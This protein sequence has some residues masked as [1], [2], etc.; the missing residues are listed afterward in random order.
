[1]IA[2]YG[3]NSSEK[4]MFLFILLPVYVVFSAASSHHLKAFDYLVDP[5]TFPAACVVVDDQGIS[6]YNYIFA[7]E[8]AGS[9]VRSLAL[10]RT[11]G[12]LLHRGK[13]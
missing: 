2:R 11:S 3:S 6:P 5:E 7:A 1:M 8:M 4:D 9:C 12:C 10:S 13:V